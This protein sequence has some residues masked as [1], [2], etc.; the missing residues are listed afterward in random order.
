MK[1]RR[2]IAD[3]LQPRTQDFVRLHRCNEVFCAGDKNGT[4]YLR[5]GLRSAI[6]RV[7]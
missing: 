3:L 5:T 4:P 1:K 6:S 7:C 2:Q